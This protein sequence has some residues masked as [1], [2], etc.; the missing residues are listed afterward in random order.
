MYKHKH[1][2]SSE[3]PLFVHLFCWLVGESLIGRKICWFRVSYLDSSGGIWSGERLELEGR[4]RARGL[5]TDGS[6]LDC[7]SSSFGLWVI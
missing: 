6:D 2:K 5:C 1:G 3:N 7:F 4:R